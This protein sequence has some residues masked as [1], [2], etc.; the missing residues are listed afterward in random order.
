MP[1]GLRR[2]LRPGDDPRSAVHRGLVLDGL[3]RRD[4]PERV[5]GG[6][7]AVH[8]GG[9][10]G[11]PGLPGRRVDGGD[12]WAPAGRP[13]RPLPLLL[14]SALRSRQADPAVPRRLQRLGPPALRRSVPDG[15]AGRLPPAAELAGGGMPSDCHRGAGS[16]QRTDR[17]R[18]DGGGVGAAPGPGLCVAGPVSRRPPDP[19][20]RPPPGRAAR[21]LRAAL[22][23]RSRASRRA[24][25]SGRGTRRR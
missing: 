11:G 24:S 6:D 22:R 1:Q 7:S 20:G 25:G 19:G 14:S 8:R 15:P 17:R 5:S 21:L 16:V 18:S 23:R 9:P 4:R 12:G 13:C 3:Q 2:P 10:E